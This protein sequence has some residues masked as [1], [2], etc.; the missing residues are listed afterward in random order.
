VRIERF[1]FA[2]TGMGVPR[3]SIYRAIAVFVSRRLDHSSRPQAMS[4]LCVSP[5]ELKGLEGR[6]ASCIRLTEARASRFV[7]HLCGDMGLAKGSR[8]D[9]AKGSCERALRKG[10]AKAVTGQRVDHQARGEIAE[11]ANR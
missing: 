4:L 2:M 9:L 6:Y 10:P 7:V 11:A 1:V 3:R 5:V 8:K